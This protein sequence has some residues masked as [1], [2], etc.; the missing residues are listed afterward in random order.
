MSP[1]SQPHALHCFYSSSRCDWLRGA[2]SGFRE[3]LDERVAATLSQLLDSR[4][5]VEVD[6]VKRPANHGLSNLKSLARQIQENLDGLA[7]APADELALQRSAEDGGFRIILAR[8]RTPCGRNWR[9]RDRDVRSGFITQHSGSRVAS[10]QPNCFAGWFWQTSF[11]ANG[12][13]SCGRGSRSCRT[14]D[15]GSRRQLVKQRQN[16]TAAC[17][18]SRR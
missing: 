7:S 15:S 18:R 11:S 4:L 16:W 1:P 17:R 13:A 8:S 5:R 12:A 3:V 9:S 2:R 10:R 14:I 6:E